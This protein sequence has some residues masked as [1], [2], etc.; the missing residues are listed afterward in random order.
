MGV[1]DVRIGTAR[2]GSPIRPCPFAVSVTGSDH[3]G[4]RPPSAELAGGDLWD[5]RLAPAA[6]VR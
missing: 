6:F 3:P 1:G 2:P 4:P 5:D